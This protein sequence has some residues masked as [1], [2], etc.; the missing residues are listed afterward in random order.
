[1]QWPDDLHVRIITRMREK[2]VV[3]LSLR[4]HHTARAWTT[5]L[6]KGKRPHAG[7]ILK[8]RNDPEAAAYCWEYAH[9][10]PSDLVDRGVG[11]PE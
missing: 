10:R 11:G 4:E 3:C 1:M 6:G 7:N 5:S 2:Q 8:V 9:R